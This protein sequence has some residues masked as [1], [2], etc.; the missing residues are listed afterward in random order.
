MTKLSV[1]LV[2]I[3]LPSFQCF[4]VARQQKRSYIPRHKSILTARN[5]G[6]KST[7]SPCRCLTTSSRLKLDDDDDDD[8]YMEGDNLQPGKMPKFY[9]FG[10]NNRSSPNQRKAMGKSST[11][12]TTINV[13]TNC[14]AEYIKW[15]GQCLTCK[16]WNTIQEMQVARGNANTPFEFSASS[17]LLQE[18]NG[19]SIRISSTSNT[20]KSFS[21]LGESSSSFNNA[22]GDA[23]PAIRLGDIYQQMKAESKKFVKNGIRNDDNDLEFFALQ[24]K[25]LVVPNNDELNNVMGGGIMPGSLTLLGG[26]PGVGKSTLAIQLAAS[27]ASLCKPQ[28]GIGMGVLEDEDDN[29]E[30]GPAIYVSGEENSWQ[31]A[32]RAARLGIQETELLLM[33]DTDADFVANMIAANSGFGRDQ[34]HQGDRRRPSLVV[35]DSIQTMLCEAGGA[36]APGGVT[37]VRETVGLFLRLAKA[38][39]IP[40]LMIGHVT[41]SGDVAGPKTVEH[42]VDTVLYLEG[43]RTG[44]NNNNVRILRASKN[45]FGSADE[46]GVYQMSGV[47]VGGGALL[48]ISDPSSFFLSTRMDTADMEGCAVSLVLEGSRCLAAEVQALVSRTSDFGSSVA[49]RRTVDGVS[50]SRVLLILAVLDKR[51]GVRFSRQDVYVNVVGGIKLSNSGGYQ[52]GGGSDLAVAVAL[53]SSLAAIPVRSDTA[54][55]GEM[56]LIGELRSVP[57]IEKRIAEA[58]RMGFS[59]VVTPKIHSKNN[60]RKKNFSSTISSRSFVEGIE[61]IECDNALDAINSGLLTKIFP[62]RPKAQKRQGLKGNENNRWINENDLLIVDDEDDNSGL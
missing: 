30:I 48:P 22:N 19:N 62:Q 25:R 10:L 57:S 50:I 21:W 39:G 29:E 60:F 34:S 37:Q 4:Q 26:D 52:K 51:Y 32:S 17:R 27:V 12:S 36:S 14:G 59:R 2:T 38:T 47:G 9:S 45:R 53:V 42:M 16:E 31:V 20:N 15:I 58:K 49:G 23:R 54:F 61:V 8:D 6:R 1:L 43:D 7:K 56:G 24:E 33:C 46:V 41:K 28:K 35:I 11:S 3:S 18:N 44:S 55:V 5:S 13:C 40:I